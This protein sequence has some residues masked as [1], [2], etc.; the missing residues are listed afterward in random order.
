MGEL[1]QIKR[2][3][4]NTFCEI[5]FSR[6]HVCAPVLLKFQC[7]SPLSVAN[8]GGLAPLVQKVLGTGHAWPSERDDT[9]GGQPRV[10]TV[11]PRRVTPLCSPSKA[12]TLET[13]RTFAPYAEQTE[14][15]RVP[16]TAPPRVWPRLWP[17]PLSVF[18]AYQV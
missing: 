11:Q 15:L 3:E 16:S 9:C 10:T 1:T 2:K 6:H 13:E 5:N 7:V 17:H 4:T 18:Q 8:W 12:S 14:S